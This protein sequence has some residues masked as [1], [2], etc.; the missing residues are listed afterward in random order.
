MLS[1]LPISLRVFSEKNRSIL[2]LSQSFHCQYFLLNLFTF[3]HI[4][5]LFGFCVISLSFIF[6]L[7]RVFAP[8]FLLSPLHS[9]CCPH[10]SVET[11]VI[12]ITNALTLSTP[13]N[14]CQSLLFVF[15]ETT[16]TSPDLPPTICMA[17]LL[18]I[19]FLFNW[20]YS[21][22]CY[23]L[24]QAPCGQC[25]SLPGSQTTLPFGKLPLTMSFHISGSTFVTE[26]WPNS[27]PLSHSPKL[28]L[29]LCSSI[30]VL[31]KARPP[32]VFYS[33]PFLS[34]TNNFKPK[35]LLLCSSSSQLLSVVCWEVFNNY[36]L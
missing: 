8:Y 19:S 5:F 18:P 24:S 32:G 17:P 13:V 4:F 30:H 23:P 3:S 6:C 9:G 31:T 15:S 20:W 12:K 25:R 7:L 22:S 1:T 27:S 10:C 21:P 16:L 28:L 11:A 14:T 34:T 29:L 35:L 26:T 36:L 33:L 2:W